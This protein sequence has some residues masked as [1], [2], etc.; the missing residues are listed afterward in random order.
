MSHKKKKHTAH[1]IDNPRCMI[2]GNKTE[3]GKGGGEKGGR[4]AGDRGRGGGKGG[5]RTCDKGRKS[6][7]WSLWCAYDTGRTST[8]R[9]KDRD[10][11]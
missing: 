6:V 8:P 4:R 5:G 1:K 7:R 3:G 9:D 10:L 2:P 11:D